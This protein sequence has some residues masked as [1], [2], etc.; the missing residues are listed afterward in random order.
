MKRDVFTATYVRSADSVV[1]A[2]IDSSISAKVRALL[3]RIA[4][5]LW[6]V[7][8]M[9]DAAPVSQQEFA[10]VPL[11]LPQ[12]I[13]PL[14]AA[15]A[16]AG[17]GA[18]RKAIAAASQASTEARRKRLA[19]LTTELAS[20][21]Q[22]ADELLTAFAR[23]GAEPAANPTVRRLAKA[24]QAPSGFLL[25]SVAAEGLSESAKGVLQKLGI[26]PTQIDVAATATLLEKQMS[27]VAGRL[28]AATGT[29][30]AMV[31]IGNRIVPRDALASGLAATAAVTL[32]ETRSPGLCPP[33]IATTPPEDSVTVPTGHGD[34]RIL[35]IAD[36]LVVEQGLLR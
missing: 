33:V 34:A 25:A 3:V 16:D 22:A 5:I 20:Y 19:E 27:S 26:A 2:A 36:L 30:G 11:V 9:A 24:N 35:G 7:R 13:F 29:S 12:G 32:D 15:D 28:Y 8:R 6:L 10:G 4:R 1:A 23:A 31:R 17:L 18:N 14:P 21:R